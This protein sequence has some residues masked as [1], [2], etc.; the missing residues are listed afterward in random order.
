MRKKVFIIHGKGRVEGIGKEGGGD[1]D[2]IGS[3][4]L[5][6]AW[7]SSELQRREG[8]QAEYGKD[9][10]FDFVNYQQGLRHLVV[11]PGSDVYLPDFP[12]DALT[13]RLRMTRITTDWEIDARNGLMIGIADLLNYTM[14]NHGAFNEN[15]RE[16]TT[17]VTHFGKTV[18]DRRGPYEIAT[19]GRVVALIRL[20]WGW[21]GEGLDDKAG[22]LI[23]DFMT[24]APVVRLREYL[25]QLLAQPDKYQ[26]IELIPPQHVTIRLAID[27]AARMDFGSRGRLSYHYD[28][29]PA[30]LVEDTTII[31]RNLKVIEAAQNLLTEEQKTKFRGYGEQ[32][33]TKTK[34]EIDS[35]LE[36]VRP[37]ISTERVALLETGFSELLS[38][39]EEIPSLLQAERERSPHDLIVHIARD[40]EGSPITNLPVI[41]RLE[42]G[43]GALVTLD[44]K[45]GA[46]VEVNTDS[47]GSAMVHYRASGPDQSY[48]V[49]ATFDELNIVVFKH[50]A[51]PAL[52]EAQAET[53][54]SDEAP[55]DDRDAEEPDGYVE[56][57]TDVVE[58]DQTIIQDRA[59]AVAQRM[60]TDDF[61]YLAEHD[62]RII[63]FDDHHPYTPGILATLMDLKQRGLLSEVQLSS[64]PKGEEQPKELQK[65]GT[66]IIYETF[67]QNSS[68]D[69]SGLALLRQLAHVQ[70]LHLAYEPLAIELSKLI[71]SK[72]SK[73]EMTRKLSLVTS[74][75]QMQ[76]IMSL[77][78]WEK[79]VRHYEQELEK[80][81]PRL[82][83]TISC[84]HLTDTA[85]TRNGVPEI[86]PVVHPKAESQN[87]KGLWSRLRRKLSKQDQPVQAPEQALEPTE[88]LR[89]YFA[90]SPFCDPRKGEP[91]INVASTLAY[92]TPHLQI[93]YFL[94]C[95][96][97]QLLTTRKVNPDARPINLS[98]LVSFI[99]SKADG[100]HAEAAT[101]RPS[102]NPEF[103]ALR[104]GRVNERNFHEYGNYLA[105]RVSA[106]AEMQGYS[107]TPRRIA[108]LS[109]ARENTLRLLA[110]NAVR[111]TLTK[112]T[113]TLTVT[114]ALLQYPPRDQ[115]ALTV[116]N[117]IAY[118]GEY[119]PSNYLLLSSSSS[120]C[121]LINTGDHTSGIKLD[122]VATH[123]GTHFDGGREVIAECRPKFNRSF[124]ISR[125][126][127]VKDARFLSFAHY[128]T[129][130]FR[131]AIGYDDFRLDPV[132]LQSFDSVMEQYIER[133]AGA[134]VR[135]VLFP[136]KGTRLTD[137]LT[138]LAVLAPRTDQSKGEPTIG[139]S[140]SLAYLLRRGIP[141]DYLYFC[142]G[143]YR[144]SLTNV[145]DQQDRINLQQM[146]ELMNPAEPEHYGRSLAWKPILK[147][148]FLRLDK[149]N[150]LVFCQAFA[151]FIAQLT[152]HKV[153][154]V[155][156]TRPIL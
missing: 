5:Y 45:T 156:F 85:G 78:G 34:E 92:L 125:F 87:E 47:R 33:L 2:T 126:G 118:L 55:S 37:H 149:T 95:Y 22:A 25:F 13:P 4:A 50:D 135:I 40:E 89:I 49:A 91:A 154:E 48:R 42:S 69:N 123:I 109:G 7:L 131:Q 145:T 151:G 111:F 136:E 12:I 24:G 63:R 62:V 82:L 104:F 43:A 44:G 147:E 124:P 152:K 134:M 112:G 71:G 1:L 79:N 18:V 31:H 103:P 120:R 28:L 39:Y 99:G 114:A 102:A 26:T 143:S 81:L 97:S 96:G 127:W 142:E 3:N 113:E 6:A 38:F 144:H 128:L 86:R 94:Y 65:C 61:E 9:Y 76:Q 140:A 138:I 122:K 35:F 148:E 130:S 115:P 54:E 59:L 17:R 23:S 98:L 46:T 14:L 32:A 129:D 141:L 53:E 70:D 72:F 132:Y 27:E 19:M 66:D 73:I 137:T 10:V 67:I 139:P 84:I 52:L 30:S 106:F 108:K 64:L 80:V 11:H 75:E 121:F 74:S 93:D 116:S 16:L 57:V 155:K 68:A 153:A 110:R 29:M 58:G 107:V 117:A 51:S 88:G 15:L 150:F 105:E 60:I 119:L 36:A 101:G 100:G 133:V 77:T 41:F 20:L 90:L 56:A 146:V 21:V 8:R 83:D